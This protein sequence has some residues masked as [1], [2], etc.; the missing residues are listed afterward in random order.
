MLSGGGIDGLPTYAPDFYQD[1]PWVEL[2]EVDVDDEDSGRKE[3][4]QGSDTQ[5]LLGQPQHIN[6][7][8][9]S[10][11]RYGRDFHLK[12]LSPN[13]STNAN[14]FAFLLVFASP[15]VALMLTQGGPAVMTQICPRK[16]P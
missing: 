4:N 16:K 8:C 14:F 10:A 15:P 5:R 11:V 9:S 7:G 12:V 13:Y 2:I 6:M 1:E 3:D